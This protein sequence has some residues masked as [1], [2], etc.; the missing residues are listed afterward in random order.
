[1]VAKYFKFRKKPINIIKQVLNIQS[2]Y[3][4]FEVT[5]NRNKCVAIGTLQP[6]PSSTFYRVKI[7]YKLNDIPRAY[8][9]SPPLNTYEN[10]V[11]IPHMYEPNRPCIYL[12]RSGE[13]GSDK[14]IARTII[15]WLSLWLF[16][17]EIWFITG[18]EWL[19]GGLHPRVGE[20]DESET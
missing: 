14:L 2:C 3:P 13:W 12:P 20:K 10:D 1:M 5:H 6:T 11:K 18:G 4:A 15:P 17:Y 7:E 8:V 19:G 9:L 16:Y